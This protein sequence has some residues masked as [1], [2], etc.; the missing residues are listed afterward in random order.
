MSRDA[1]EVP[2]FPV[3]RDGDDIEHRSLL[4]NK[5]LPAIKDQV[6]STEKLYRNFY[7]MSIGFGI[8]H[9]CAVTCLA[10]ASTELGD[11]MGSVTCGILFV[12]YALTS[13]MLAKPIVSSLGPKLSMLLASIG[14]TIYVGGFFISIVFIDVTFLT[15][16]LAWLVSVVTAVIGGVSGGLMWTAQGAFFAQN[17][18]L[19]CENTGS[20]LEEVNNTFASIFAT[21]FLGIEMIT[22]LFATGV[23]LL[24]PTGYWAPCVIFSL[25]T[26]VSFISCYLIA[27]MH[28]L[29][30]GPNYDFSYKVIS[31]SAGAAAKLVVKEPRMAL[32]VPYQLAFGFTSSFVPYYVFGTVVSRSSKLGSTYVGVLSAVVALTAA[33]VAL[34][35]AFLAHRYGKRYVMFIGG[36]CLLIVGGC[37]FI[38]DDETLGTWYVMFP[39]LI[40]Y[41]IGRGVWESSNKAVIT[42]FF[43]GSI[44]D[45]TTAF[46]VIEFFNGYAGA[47][48]YFTF[49][50]LPRKGMASTV[51]TLS[52]MGMGFY[53]RAFL[54]NDVKRA[55]AK[56]DKK[57]LIHEEYLKYKK[58]HDHSNL[59]SSSEDHILYYSNGNPSNKS[60]DNRKEFK[61]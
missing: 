4:G 16:K 40:V 5:N 38:A 14:Y 58:E 15:M 31:K 49:M 9:G 48:A 10:F 57:A 43:A 45:T 55:E 12:G 59:A 33:S 39:L 3:A 34:P 13:F 25:Y 7:L 60:N 50:Y 35:S 42:D 6:L 61:Y 2:L 8:I 18:K 29:G 23:Y 27:A 56:I 26:A 44:E 53:F 20:D 47:L 51:V 32:L 37:F 21:S 54:L 22:K 46:T 41:G 52:F 28:D 19:F 24:I 36:L 30:V 17:S 1:R 11:E